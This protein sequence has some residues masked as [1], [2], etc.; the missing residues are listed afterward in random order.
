M[1]APITEFDTV[2]QFAERHHE[3]TDAEWCA[4]K[5]KM[6]AFNK[7]GISFSAYVVK[8]PSGRGSDDQFVFWVNPH[9]SGDE[10]PAFGQKCKIRLVADGNRSEWHAAKKSPE[11]K[12]LKGPWHKYAEFNIAPFSSS[13][14]E[15]NE[16]VVLHPGTRN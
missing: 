6:D 2:E 8:V 5:A 11:T 1:E 12:P 9:D 15:L 10:F 7:S 16:E 4:E 3:A 14:W 13:D